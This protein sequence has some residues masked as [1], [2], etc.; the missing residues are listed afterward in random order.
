MR[1]TS[2]L[3]K[4]CTRA[5]MINGSWGGSRNA[6]RI[7]KRSPERNSTIAATV[8]SGAET[9]VRAGPGVPSARRTDARSRPAMLPATVKSDIEVLDCLCEV[10]ALAPQPSFQ[11]AHVTRSEAARDEEFA[12]RHNC[13]GEIHRRIRMQRREAYQQQDQHCPGALSSAITRDV[14]EGLGRAFG[15]LR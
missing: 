4:S 2:S 14:D 7:R 6:A 1:T 3:A 15:R 10:L 11:R 13:C 8:R 9:V 5:P 12:S